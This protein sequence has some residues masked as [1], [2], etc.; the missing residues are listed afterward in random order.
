MS[1][2]VYNRFVS[3]LALVALAVGVLLLIPPVR[4]RSGFLAPSR[5]WLASLVALT[6]TGGSLVY[7][8]V[9][10][11]EPCR[12]CWYQRIAMY[13][14]GLILLIAAWKRDWAVRRYVLPLAGVGAIIA[15]YHYALQ[16]FPG[17]D[18]GACSVG[19]PCT[20]KYVNEFGFISIPFMAFSGFLAVIG[21]VSLKG[22]T[23]GE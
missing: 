8:E 3:L 17:L 1:V 16:T 12:L 4:N 6:S 19:V 22:A 9:F 20:A 7:S 23:D 13:P 15:A 11:F 18:T 2:F 10:N 14:L 21:L 5:L